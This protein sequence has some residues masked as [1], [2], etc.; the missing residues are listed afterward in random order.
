MPLTAGLGLL[1][2]YVIP[3]P[4]ESYTSTTTIPSIPQ[5]WQWDIKTE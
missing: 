2:P 3:D 1:A 4:Y 5:A